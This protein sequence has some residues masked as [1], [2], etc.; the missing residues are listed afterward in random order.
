MI[1]GGS[2]ISKPTCRNASG[3]LG[4]SVFFLAKDNCR[5]QYFGLLACILFGPRPDF[6]RGTRIT[7]AGLKELQSLHNLKELILCL[8]PGGPFDVTREGVKELRAALAEANI[9]R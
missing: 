5:A 2:L 4:T 3:Q 7:D 8:V 6:L 1:P 9:L